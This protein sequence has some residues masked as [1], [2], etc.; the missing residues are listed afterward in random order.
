MQFVCAKLFAG[1]Y[2]RELEAESRNALQVVRKIA[3][4]DS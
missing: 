4:C 1:V 2:D 3:P